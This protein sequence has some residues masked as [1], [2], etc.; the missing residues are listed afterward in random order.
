VRKLA[1]LTPTAAWP[2]HADPLTGDVAA[3]RERAAAQG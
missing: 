2:A 3:Q 1:E